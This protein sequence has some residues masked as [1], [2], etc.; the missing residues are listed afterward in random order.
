ME[1]LWK[2]Y[3][4]PAILR[5]TYPFSVRPDR[6]VYLTLVRDMGRLAR[7]ILAMPNDAYRGWKSK[8]N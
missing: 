5:V 2:G 6:N 4:R 1:E 8:N 3:T 7:T